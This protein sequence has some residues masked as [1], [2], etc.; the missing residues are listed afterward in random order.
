MDDIVDLEE[1]KINL[2]LNK[3]ENDPEPEEI[4][5]VEKILWLKIRNR[6]LAGRRTGLSA[7]GLADCLAALSIRYGSDDSISVSEEIYKQF[8]ISA[9]KSSIDM[10]KERGAFPIWNYELEKNNPFLQK[11]NN[12]ICWDD[13]WIYDAEVTGRRNISLLTIP[14]SGTISLLAGISSGI[15][16]VYQLHY[17]RRR[18]LEKG[19]PNITFIDQNGD[20]WEEYV[21]YHPKFKEWYY[22]DPTRR[23]L[24]IEHPNNIKYLEA[25]ITDS[26]NPYLKTTAYEIDPIQ[27]IKLQAKIQKWIDHSISS[28]IN[29]S[30]NVSEA[31]V[32]N[33]YF[34]AWKEE[35]KGITIYRNN[36][37]TGVLVD[38]EKKDREFKQH[39]APK[40]PIILPAEIYITKSKGEEWVV[41]IGLLEDKPYE[42]FT[43]KNKWNFT[44]KYG[45][46][47][48]KGKGIYDLDIKDDL[49]IENFTK[50]I[51]DDENL[52]TRMM[53]TSLRHG[54]D[55]KF[56]VE[57]LNTSKG[58][59]TNFAH[60]TSRILKKYIQD[61]EETNELCPDCKS[62][63]TYT[64]GCKNC[65]QCGYSKCG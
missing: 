27:R 46:V 56:I 4:K 22:S 21:V 60:A 53:S 20:G 34:T 1:E 9:Y 42:I 17:K 63:L 38:I 5:S 52:L 3:I 19:N 58:D 24:I 29:L 12:N 65:T 47:I 39:S 25:I 50:D 41:V 59:I 7:I 45:S 11:I 54:S 49:Y 32:S 35:C 8:A 44:G 33:I 26:E 16:P 10:A 18:K 57:Q 61:G 30:E 2:I 64:N 51:P 62:K 37:R 15:E 28:T 13:S 6:L 55:I 36:C 31:D 40:R 14:P 48:K 43:I 23:K